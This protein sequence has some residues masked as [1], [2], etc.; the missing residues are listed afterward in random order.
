MAHS[1]SAPTLVAGQ[2]DCNETPFVA[3]LATA[4]ARY[5]YDVNTNRI[6]RVSR[7]LFEALCRVLDKGWPEQPDR[8]A[9]TNPGFAEMLRL[10]RRGLLLGRGL[11]CFRMKEHRPCIENA[12]RNELSQL[13]FEITEACNLRCAY[14]CPLR[15]DVRPP[16]RNRC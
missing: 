6:L 4:K 9:L 11:R 3:A 15:F 14:L 13:T 8:E 12:I 5:V 7:V 2:A 10:R 1:P 16:G